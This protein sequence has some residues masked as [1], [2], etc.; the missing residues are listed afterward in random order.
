MLHAAKNKKL[1]H[2]WWHPHNFGINLK[3]NIHFL[4]KIL[5]YYTYLKTKYNFSN[6]TMKGIADQL[7]PKG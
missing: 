7:R 6:H 2:L 1:F 5:G 4:E 3:E